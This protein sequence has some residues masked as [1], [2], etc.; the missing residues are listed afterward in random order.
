MTLFE[1]L[2]DETRENPKKLN[3]AAIAKTKG[4]GLCLDLVQQHAERVIKAKWIIV[5][6][7]S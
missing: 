3:T 4:R 6:R 2:R 7:T 1:V 5:N